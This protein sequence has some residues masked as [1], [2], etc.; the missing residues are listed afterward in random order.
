MRYGV[1]VRTGRAEIETADGV[2]V[3]HVAH[4]DGVGPFP[5]VIVYMPASGIR[6]ELIGIAQRIASAGYYTVLPNLYYRL[7]ANVDI[8]AN[9]LGQ[10]DY[11]PVAD[12]M[13][14][15]SGNLTNARVIADTG[16]II[17]F[18]DSRPAAGSER[19]GGVGYCMGGR[20]VM[21]SVGAHPERMLAAASMYGAGIV[22][23]EPDSAHR[24]LDRVV[25]ELYFGLA[26]NDIYV[27]DA[28]TAALK[29][30]LATLDV[31]N[32]VELYPGTEHGFC[33]P[34]RYCYAPEATA[35]HY[36]RLADLFA[37]QLS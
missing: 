14:A 34:E 35:R 13:I 33:F 29:A 15:L 4:P 2:M 36:E 37:R 21:A 16:A 11:Q 10:A 17:D 30:H 20:L 23:D 32:T 25:G 28:E 9:R 3:V 22:T 7:A 26:E 27:D 8:D 5:A 18:L 1:P 19:I 24:D 31:V 12:Y 6:D